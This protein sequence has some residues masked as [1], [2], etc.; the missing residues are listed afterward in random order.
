M[1]A[2]RP[3]FVAIVC[4]LAAIACRNRGGPE[5]GAVQAKCAPGQLEPCRRACDQGDDDACDQ[6]A[7]MY[8]RGSGA[9][10]SDE[11]AVAVYKRHCEAGRRKL[12]PSYAFALL[13]GKG[14]DQDAAR[15]R[16]LFA[17][18]CQYDPEACGEYGSL[19][20]VGTGVPQ[21]FQLG[22]D[23]LDAACHHGNAPSCRDLQRLRAAAGF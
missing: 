23:L 9:E 13:L 6:V 18:T 12:C 2:Q 4:A 22:V 17:D 20:A 14:I 8:L 3:I 16:R 1:S 11:N 10:Q 5:N 7:R 15:A 19:L 21:D